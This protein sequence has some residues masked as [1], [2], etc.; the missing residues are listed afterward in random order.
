[1]TRTVSAWLQH[2][3]SDYRFAVRDITVDFY[4]AEAR[5][6]RP[7]CSLEQLRRFNDTCLDMAEIC[8]I[9]GD[10]RSYLHA[11]GKLHHRLI[12]EMGNDDRDRLFRPPV[13]DAFMPKACTKRRLGPD[14]GPAA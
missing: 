10:D 5:L 8:D 9:N 7:E 13:A 2:K 14:N 12:Q 4:L 3:I 11:L 6:N 1:M